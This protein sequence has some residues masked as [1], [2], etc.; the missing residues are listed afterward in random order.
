MCRPLGRFPFADTLVAYAGFGDL[1]GL[2]R[3]MAG[4]GDEAAPVHGVFVPSDPSDS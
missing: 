1:E 4:E 2:I 3:V